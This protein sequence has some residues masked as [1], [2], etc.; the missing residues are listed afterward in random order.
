MN[1]VFSPIRFLPKLVR[2]NALGSRISTGIP[3]IPQVRLLC[4]RQWNIE[5]EKVQY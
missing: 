5:D 1:L 4:Y 2:T 3:G